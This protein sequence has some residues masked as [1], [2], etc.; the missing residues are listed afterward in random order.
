[1]FLAEWCFKF[2]SQ[3]P[4]DK[5]T[6]QV[7]YQNLVEQAD[8]GEVCIFVDGLDELAELLKCDPKVLKDESQSAVSDPQRELSGAS[9]IAG[10]LRKSILPGAYVIATGRPRNI[11]T[12]Q[13]R[14]M[15]NSGVV[16]EVEPFSDSDVEELIERT[17]NAKEKERI[18]TK[19]KTFMISTSFKK[20][21]AK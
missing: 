4:W 12:V 8:R 14:L 5:K 18:L 1:M 13:S 7:Y 17:V 20:Y 19:I 16:F 15:D 3:K 6:R 2:G 9:F 21:T 11:A 10:V